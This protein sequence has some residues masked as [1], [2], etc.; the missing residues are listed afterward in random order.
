MLREVKISVIVPIYNVEKY[1]V[2]CIDSIL[3]QEFSDYEIICIEDCSTDN[4]YNVLRDRY[5]NNIFSFYIW[6]VII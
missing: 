6:I 3:N 1:L 2:S 5:K 4:S